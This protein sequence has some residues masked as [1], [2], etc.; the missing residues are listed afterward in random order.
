MSLT[1]TSTQ[2]LYQQYGSESSFLTVYNQSGTNIT[3]TIATSGSNGVPAEDTTG[4][5]EGEETLDVESANAI[6]RGQRLMSSR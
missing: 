2:T 5:W 6:A 4:H 3:S 1:T